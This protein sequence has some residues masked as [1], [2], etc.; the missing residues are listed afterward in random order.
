MTMLLN[1]ERLV[2][3]N[4]KDSDL[5]SFLSYR[6]DPEA[7]KYQGWDIPYTREQ[8]EKL[9]KDM[10]DM[11]AP[12]QGH[13]LQLVVE[14]KDAGEMI[15]DLGC[16]I[17]SDDARQAAI[18]FTIAPA[19]WRKGYAAEAVSCLL[20]FLFDDLDLHRVAADCDVENTSSWRML[21]KLGFRREAHF[22]ENLFFKGVYASEYHYGQLQREWRM[23][24]S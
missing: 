12:K 14:L 21:E 11:H 10:K 20:E 9:I 15:G 16:F 5:E 7:A 24:K 22:V 1:A 17:R 8:G 18:G 6:N 19:H 4:F 23:R 2:L 3:R 13:W